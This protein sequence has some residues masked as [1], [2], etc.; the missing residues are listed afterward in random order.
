M[1]HETRDQELF[2]LNAAALKAGFINAAAG[3]AACVYGMLTGTAIVTGIAVGYLI[4]AV[5]MSWLLRI[6]CK[7]VALA[8][9]AAARSVAR[10]YYVRYAA[11]VFIF[12][13]FITKGWLSP[14]QLVIGF[15]L[16]VFSI[17]GILTFFAFDNFRTPLD[18]D[19]ELKNV[20]K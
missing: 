2:G 9:E 1:A 8:P 13:L 3:A 19:A 20:S 6:A 17:I 12:A 15:S 14:W 10:S 16:S 18:A 11:T 5:N 7:G 4:G